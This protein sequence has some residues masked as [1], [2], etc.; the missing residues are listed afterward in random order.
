MQKSME[1]LA[2]T[3][4][5]P[6]E[7]V[8]T[9]ISIV[10]ACHS[11]LVEHWDSLAIK[12]KNELVIREIDSQL[13]PIDNNEKKNKAIDNLLSIYGGFLFEVGRLMCFVNNQDDRTTLLREKNMLHLH[14]QGVIQIVLEQ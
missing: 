5:E 10:Q 6:G 13:V 8:R 9:L 12:N 3:I 7:E 1:M 14:I 4:K 11:S 2:R